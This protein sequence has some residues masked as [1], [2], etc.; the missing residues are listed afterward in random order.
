MALR[1][2]PPSSGPLQTQPLRGTPCAGV[3]NTSACLSL[4]QLQHASGTSRCRRQ[5]SCS[6]AGRGGDKPP[7]NALSWMFNRG[8][9]LLNIGRESGD[10]Q[11]ADRAERRQ[12]P[13]GSANPGR[14]SPSEDSQQELAMQRA[15]SSLIVSSAR[16][17][18][19]E[20]PERHSNSFESWREVG[21]LLPAQATLSSCAQMLS[22]NCKSLLQVN[23]KCC[24]TLDPCCFP[25]TANAIVMCG[26]AVK[27]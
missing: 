22:M 16:Q 14:S 2:R 19:G 17:P 25:G 27:R 21:H 8:K 15:S 12:Q 24:C 10:P 5:V 7:Q 11:Q 23:F 1:L 4:K 26:T 3:C 9:E 20:K 6:A 13:D 18:G